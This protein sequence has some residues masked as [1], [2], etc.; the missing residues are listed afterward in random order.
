MAEMHSGK[1]DNFGWS[2]RLDSMEN[3]RHTGFRLIVCM[4]SAWLPVLP[5]SET[6]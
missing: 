2:G 3:V 6:S 5:C 1:P 4:S